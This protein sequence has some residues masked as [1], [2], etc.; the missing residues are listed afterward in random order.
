M[1]KRAAGACCTIDDLFRQDLKVLA[2]VGVFITHDAHRPQPAMADANDLIA[3]AQ[4][5]NG[6]RANRGI[7]PRHIPAA[8]E[9]TDQAFLGA[10]ATALS[11]SWRYAK[12]KSTEAIGC[13]RAIAQSLRVSLLAIYRKRLTMH[14]SQA[15]SRILGTSQRNCRRDALCFIQSRFHTDSIFGQARNTTVQVWAIGEGFGIG[16]EFSQ[17]CCAANNFRDHDLT[18]P[19]NSLPLPDPTHAAWIG[20]DIFPI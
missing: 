9:N 3:F 2:V 15:R 10:H 1:Q 7:E 8:G 13:A 14:G 12:G 17:T 16:S 4:G 5:A 19:L 6:D 18:S 20:S 11:F